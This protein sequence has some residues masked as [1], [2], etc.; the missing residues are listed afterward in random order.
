MC[1]RQLFLCLVRYRICLVNST[2]L[3]S[4]QGKFCL[5]HRALFALFATMR[6][7]STI[8]YRSSPPSPPQPLSFGLA[9]GVW[10]FGERA[11]DAAAHA[12]HRHASRKLLMPREQR[13]EEK[14][15]AAV[16]HHRAEPEEGGKRAPHRC[17]DPPRPVGE[18]DVLA[19]SLVRGGRGGL[20]SA[21]RA[22]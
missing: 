6:V 1:T 4:S 19:I 18:L 12:G 8:F 14:A 21:P 9:F 5:I 13:R 22:L 11:R 7:L 3:A 2:F 17:R 15:K 20:T 16:G 10:D